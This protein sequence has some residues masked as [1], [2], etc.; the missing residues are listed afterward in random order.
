MGKRTGNAAKRWAAHLAAAKHA[1]MTLSKYAQANRLSV[2][3]LYMARHLEARGSATGGAGERASKQ[4]VPVKLSSSA[5]P[6]SSARVRARLANGVALEIELAD[7]QS[8]LLGAFV[9]TLARLPCSD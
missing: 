6:S 8:N 5:S 9:S 2:S 3:S 1:G 4:F 7:A